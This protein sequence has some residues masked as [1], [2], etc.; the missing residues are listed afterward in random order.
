MEEEVVEVVLS[1][2][3]AFPSP[4]L[5]K[6]ASFQVVSFQEVSFLVEVVLS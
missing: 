1:F 2:M 3:E 6:V 4:F 5:V